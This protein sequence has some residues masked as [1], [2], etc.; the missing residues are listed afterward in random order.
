MRI[1]KGGQKSIKKKKSRK[2]IRK[3]TR[4]KTMKTGKKK[5]HIF[6]QALFLIENY[7]ILLKIYHF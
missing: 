4:K 6:F 1:Q 3:K 2:K 5:F 7:E